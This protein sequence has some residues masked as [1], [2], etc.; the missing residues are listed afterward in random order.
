[1][2]YTAAKKAVSE[3]THAAIVGDALITAFIDVALEVGS[4]IRRE[5]GRIQIPDR[6]TAVPHL[7]K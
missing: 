2:R 1:M 5:V 7:N 4:S 3:R 6:N